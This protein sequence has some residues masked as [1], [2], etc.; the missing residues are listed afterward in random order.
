MMYS[1]AWIFGFVDGHVVFPIQP[2]TKDWEG[3]FNKS[4][5]FT[6]VFQSS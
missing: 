3:H 2:N 4:D 6:V 1:P 5:N